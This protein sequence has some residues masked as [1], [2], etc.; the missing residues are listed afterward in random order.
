VAGVTLRDSAVSPGLGLV[1][2]PRPSISLF[3]SYSQGYE[4][5]APGQFAEGGGP[6]D[7]IESESFE[8]GAKA[9]VLGARLALSGS[10]YRIRQTGVAEAD[11]RGFYRQIAEGE[12]TGVELEA[13]G[14]PVPGLEVLAGYS[15]CD[16]RISQDLSGFEENALPLAPRHKANAWVRYRFAPERLRRLTLGAGVLH[17]SER[18][19]T[20]DNAVRLPPYTRI[21]LTASL[22]L[23]GPKLVLGL[24][25][26][27]L[28]DTRYVTSGTRGA[29]IAGSPRRLAASLT[30]RF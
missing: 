26:T 23:A 25:A 28:A 2:L 12:S 9:S 17:V 16:A 13:V 5:P 7:P 22:E 8:A 19:A 20:R 1:F 4:A 27:N 6:L 3:A 14:T 10:V 15:W 21:D 11:A 30:S 18:F 24:V 29:F